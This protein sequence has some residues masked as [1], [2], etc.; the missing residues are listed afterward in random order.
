M[1]EKRKEK[2]RSRKRTHKEKESGEKKM[3]KNSKQIKDEGKEI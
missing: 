3:T 1:K 2:K